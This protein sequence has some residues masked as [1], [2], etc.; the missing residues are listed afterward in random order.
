M[1]TLVPDVDAFSNIEYTAR[2]GFCRLFV[3][4]AGDP[5]LPWL[6]LHHSLAFVTF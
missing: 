4:V 1:E 3:V 6:A 5:S 2:L